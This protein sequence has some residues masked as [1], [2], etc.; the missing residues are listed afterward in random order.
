MVQ[1]KDTLAFLG[2]G[3]EHV[4]HVKS[5]MQPIAE[6]DAA[7]KQIVEFFGGNAPPMAFTEWSSSNP[8][9]I[10]IIA[11]SPGESASTPLEYLTPLG[12]EASPVFSR[13]AKV[14]HPSTIYVS[15]LWGDEG[16]SSEQQIYSI[17]AALKKVLGETDS[18][19]NHLVKATYYPATDDPSAKLNLIRP[20]YYDPKRPPAASKALV[21]GTGFAGRTITLDMIAV[22]AR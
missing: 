14:Y 17:F 1:L 12:D 8:I 22:P 4:I 18:D 13:I 11:T 10:E 3:L 19:L 9:E 5:F 6:M 15:G 2:L 21:A 7:E 16:A 20:K